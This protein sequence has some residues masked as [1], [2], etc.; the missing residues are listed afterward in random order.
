[1]GPQTRSQTRQNSLR[2]TIGRREYETPRKTQFYDLYDAQNQHTTHASLCRQLGI[3][4][5]TGR[6]WLHQRELL[7]PQAYRRTRPLSE[8]LGQPKK[9][10]YEAC[11]ALLS[12]SKNPVRDQPYEVQIE[13][14]SL[15]VHPDTLRRSLAD[16][17]QKAGL[18]K[19]AYVKKQI[20]ASTYP[21]RVQH[22]TE[23]KD[24]TIDDFWQWVVFTDEAHYDPSSRSV[25]RV[26]REQGTRYNSENITQRGPR[27]GSTI[28]F[29]G[30]CNWHAKAPE[31][32][33]YN[34]EKDIIWKPIIQW[35]PKR[36]KQESEAAFQQRLVEIGKNVPSVPQERSKSNSMTENYYT[37]K[38]LPKYAASVHVLEQHFNHKFYLQEDNDPSHGTRNSR[39]QAAENFRKQNKLSVIKQT[40]YSP[41]LNPQEACWNI[42]KQ[43]VRKRTWSSDE[44]LRMV[45]QEEWS[46]ITIKEVRSRIQEIPKRYNNVIRNKGKPVRSSLW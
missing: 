27:T 12:P 3:D 20:P 15:N 10:S 19:Q 14:H 30:W 21:Q 9:L 40:A 13:H 5:K 38:I 25:G 17:T 41:D 42:L 26:L 45:L 24:K 35:L 6:N 44:E 23:Y 4:R 36:S 8:S 43:R 22:C 28:H 1:M 39:S 16:Y 34:D 29:A 32:I 2:R 37:A 31:L 46:K 11:Q 33:F 7:G 18:Y